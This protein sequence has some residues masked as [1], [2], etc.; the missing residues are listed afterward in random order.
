MELVGYIQAAHFSSHLSLPLNSEEGRLGQDGRRAVPPKSPCGHLCRKG[1]E[2]AN[3]AKNLSVFLGK[4]GLSR[5]K[6]RL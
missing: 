6:H 1:C 3:R 2:P 4:A 5:L